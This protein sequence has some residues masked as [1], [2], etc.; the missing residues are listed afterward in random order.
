MPT[1]MEPSTSSHSLTPRILDC[2]ACGMTSVASANLWPAPGLR[3]PKVIASCD[4]TTPEG[5][6]GVF[7]VVVAAVVLVDEAE[8]GAALERLLPEGRRRPF[9]WNREGPTA[10]SAM[11]QTIGEIGVV[12][13]VCVHY[14]TGRR[15]QE[16]ARARC[17]DHL[18]QALVDDGIH[19]LRIE[20]RS[21]RQDA[22]D[23]ATILDVFRTIGRPGAF[24]YGWWPKE[25]PLL[26]IADAICGAPD[27]AG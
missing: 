26:W 7:Y 25:E 20:S 4:E 13:H 27:A 12:S 18:T 22:R 9:H 10:R 17:L 11:L 14:P 24:S 21:R 19:E 1:A 6:K 5:P 3:S 16:G 23:Q 15:R 2:K 8:A